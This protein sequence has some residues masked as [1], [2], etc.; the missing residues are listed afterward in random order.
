MDN[1]FLSSIFFYN[2]LEGGALNTTPWGL[3]IPK[4]NAR[5]LKGKILFTHGIGF[6]NPQRLA[7]K[8]NLY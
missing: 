7:F 5:F 4:L 3:L 2:N 8:N 6:K 1:F